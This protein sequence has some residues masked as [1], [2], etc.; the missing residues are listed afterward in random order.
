M[1]NTTPRNGTADETSPLLGQKKHS[2]SISIRFRKHMTS[3][4]SKHRADIVLL[5][6]YLITGLIDSS[7]V[8]IWGAFASMQTG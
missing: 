2:D 8:Y 4:V 5:F 1:D 7:A 6:G 3:N